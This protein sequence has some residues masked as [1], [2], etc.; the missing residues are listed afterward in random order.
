MQI[1]IYDLIG[2]AGAG[3]LVAAYF[4]NQQGWLASE[5]WRFP[6]AN[7]AGSALIFISLCFA[8]NFPSVVIEIFWAAISLWGIIKAL[9]RR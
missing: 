4:A 8:W 9:S 2:F 1:E 6:A 5:D 7:L 3:V